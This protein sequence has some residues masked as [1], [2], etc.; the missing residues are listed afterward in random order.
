M[1]GLGDRWRRVYPAYDR[2]PSVYER[3][4]LAMTWGQVDRW[5]RQLATL[6]PQN[7]RRVLDAGCGPGNMTRHLISAGRY[8][9]GLDYSAEM[10]KAMRLDVDKV[11]GV[12][13]M[14]PFRDGAFDVAVL[15][16][17]LHA[18]KDL[19]KALAELTRVAYGVAAISMGKPDSPLIRRLF[20]LYVAYLVPTLARILAPGHVDEYKALKEILEAAVPNRDLK[21]LL[22]KSLEL[23]Y[24]GT[25]GLGAIYMFYG[26]RPQRAVKR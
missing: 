19:E 26:E 15:A 10:L 11:Q 13:E 5:R 18:A 24:F 21:A 8:V 6:L 17:A 22:E 1:T 3:M 4:N 7:A 12:F 20:G 25:R 14:L 2:L 16:Y 9:V 23:K